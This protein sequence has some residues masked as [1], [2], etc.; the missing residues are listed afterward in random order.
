MWLCST[1]IIQDKMAI[2]ICLITIK[3]V[4]LADL[5]ISSFLKSSLIDTDDKTHL[6]WGFRGT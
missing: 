6:G 5:G 2:I 1:Y 4:L 3:L